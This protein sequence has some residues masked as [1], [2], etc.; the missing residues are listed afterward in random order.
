MR[1][2][3]R[4]PV[5][6]KVLIDLD[7]DLFAIL[8]RRGTDKRI[9]ARIR[10]ASPTRNVIPSIAAQKPSE[11]GRVE[12]VTGARFEI[13]GSR[14]LLEEF[15]EIAQ[16]GCRGVGTLGVP[17]QR[18]SRRQHCQAG[19]G[20]PTPVGSRRTIARA[21]RTPVRLHGSEDAEA[22]QTSRVGGATLPIGRAQR[23]ALKID[24]GPRG[25][26]IG[27]GGGDADVRISWNPSLPVSK[28]SIAGGVGQDRIG[29]ESTLAGNLLVPQ[30][31]EER[32]VFDDRAAE[33]DRVLIRVSPIRLGG[34]PA[35]RSLPR[36][37][38]PG[39]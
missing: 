17:Q 20:P 22:D 21:E 15:G 1:P 32:L 11:R 16:R 23:S 2:V 26:G 5:P 31:D 28:D 8:I 30:Y 7:V 34:F 29:L 12:T 24:S 9:L 14:H 35:R 33:A 13:V 27:G 10:A 25:V 19:V 37:L 39:Q 4:D 6:A 38:A 3:P 18:A 36:N